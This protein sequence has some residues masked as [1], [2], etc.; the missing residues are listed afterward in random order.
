MKTY[1]EILS[2]ARMKHRNGIGVPPK[3]RGEFEGVKNKKEAVQMFFRLYGAKSRTKKNWQ[4]LLSD[5]H[6]DEVI[7]KR[8]K[9]LWFMDYEDI[10]MEE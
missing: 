8:Q 1:N 5:L 3:K 7:T 9:M 4:G 10:W 6:K 2:E